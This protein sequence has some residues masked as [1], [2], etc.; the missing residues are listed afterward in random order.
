[1]TPIMRPEKKPNIKANALKD[2]QYDA[3][4]IQN[5]IAAPA[6]KQFILDEVL[7]TILAAKGIVIA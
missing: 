4:Y 1:M 3:M 7:R 6:I 2:W 5:A